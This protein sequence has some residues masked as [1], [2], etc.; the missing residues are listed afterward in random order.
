MVLT[1]TRGP[2]AQVVPLIPYIPLSNYTLPRVGC[3]PGPSQR[4][5]DGCH[6]AEM[7]RPSVTVDDQVH[8][9][10]LRMRPQYAVHEPLERG[11]S[12]E[13]PEWHSFKLI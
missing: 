5:K 9:S 13:Q 12:P 11:R 4:L 10:I 8:R 1:G 6:P 3:E 7:L 2:A